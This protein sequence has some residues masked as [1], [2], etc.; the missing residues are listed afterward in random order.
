MYYWTLVLFDT[1]GKFLFTKM[2]HGNYWFV[3]DIICLYTK[4]I[5]CSLAV[6]K[7]FLTNTLGIGIN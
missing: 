3:C 7:I 6:A 1:P 4:N 2:N 5:D